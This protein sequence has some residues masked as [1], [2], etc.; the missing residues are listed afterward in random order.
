MGVFNNNVVQTQKDTMLLCRRQ[1]PLFRKCVGCTHA[2]SK[3]ERKFILKKEN[4]NKQ[5]N[6]GHREY[7][8]RSTNEDCKILGPWE[9]PSSFQ[10]CKVWLH[11]S[12]FSMKRA[13]NI[14]KLLK[15]LF[16]SG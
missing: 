4:R 14:L 7:K 12:C 9:Q 11:S 2:A 8:T 5:E 16:G 13:H 15:L 3:D 10:I 6:V 1:L